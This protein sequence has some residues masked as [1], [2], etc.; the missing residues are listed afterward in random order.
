MVTLQQAM[1]F[2][3]R[4][5]GI[6]LLFLQPRRRMGGEWSTPRPGRFT[7]GEETRYTLYRGLC[8]PQG[9]SGRMRKISAPTGIRSPD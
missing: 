7:H 4:S 1:K 8:G 9:L 6:A 3:R 5:R 2:R